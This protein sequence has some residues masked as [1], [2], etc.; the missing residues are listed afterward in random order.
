MKSRESLLFR[1]THVSLFQLFLND[2]LNHTIQI[3]HFASCGIEFG[4]L[5]F[6]YFADFK[7]LL[8]IRRHFFESTRFFGTNFTSKI[9]LFAIE[10]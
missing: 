10:L 1:Y 8:Y 3:G 4:S 9:F 5:I 7:S 2:T 6:Y